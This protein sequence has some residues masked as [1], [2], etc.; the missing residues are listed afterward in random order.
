MEGGAT[1][2]VVVVT[3]REVV[4]MAVASRVLSITSTMRLRVELR[5]L[6]MI[7]GFKS[8]VLLFEARLELGG[9]IPLIDLV[10]CLCFRSWLLPAL[11]VVI[12]H[13]E[14]IEMSRCGIGWGWTVGGREEDGGGFELL[15]EEEALRSGGGRD[16]MT[17]DVPL[18]DVEEVPKTGGTR[19]GDTVDVWAA[20]MLAI[21]ESSGGPT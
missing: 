21:G 5:A 16:G 20:G 9:C 3:G 4:P 12:E 18:N 7:T 11:P 2:V 10:S 14:P 1:E 8:L 6:E 17:E 13:D 19:V 15:E